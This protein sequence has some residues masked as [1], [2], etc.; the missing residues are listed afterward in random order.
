[1]FVGQ[2]RGL[3]ACFSQRRQARRQTAGAR[4][5][6]QPAVFDLDTER[7][8]IG[9][10]DQSSAAEPAALGVFLIRRRRHSQATAPPSNRYSRAQPKE[11]CWRSWEPRC[12]ALISMSLLGGENTTK[13]D[14]KT[15][16]DRRPVDKRSIEAARNLWSFVGS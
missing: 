16:T 14:S 6:Q 9:N 12:G 10:D 13:Q 3:L 11:F 8:T 7:Q 15:G 1:M 5:E 2:C 4:L